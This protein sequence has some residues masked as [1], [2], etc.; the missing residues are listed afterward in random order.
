M[1]SAQQIWD[2]T[3]RVSAEAGFDVRTLD[4]KQGVEKIRQLQE[5][6]FMYGVKLQRLSGDVLI[7]KM[8]S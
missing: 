3:V 1:R 2:E 5:E 7:E 6:A 4:H 8:P